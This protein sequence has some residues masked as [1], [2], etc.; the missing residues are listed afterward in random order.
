MLGGD[1]RESRRRE[2]AIS[3]GFSYF[4][5]SR[6]SIPRR[7]VKEVERSLIRRQSFLVVCR[8][9]ATPRAHRAWTLGRNPSREPRLPHSFPSRG[10]F[11]R[12]TAR[13]VNLIIERVQRR[14]PEQ[15]ERTP[16]PDP[17]EKHAF[18]K[19]PGQ[20]KGAGSRCSQRPTCAQ[21]LQSVRSSRHMSPKRAGKR[22]ELDEVEMKSQAEADDDWLAQ[23]IHEAVLKMS[24]FFLRVTT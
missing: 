9:P 13:V 23:L 3:A 12:A 10:R 5:R 19:E 11:A 16:A 18:A 14:R 15:R 4:S 2:L 20:T 1:E 8:S 7:S 6:S 24:D 17:H 22:V 21:S